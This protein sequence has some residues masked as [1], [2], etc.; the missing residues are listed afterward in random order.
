MINIFYTTLYIFLY[1]F[2][3]IDLNYYVFLGISI[4]VIVKG[5]NGHKFSPF[6]YLKIFDIKYSSKNILEMFA[7]VEFFVYYYLKNGVINNLES[8]VTLPSLIIF[9]YFASFISL[10]EENEND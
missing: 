2:S 9:F 5:L 10:N 6:R 8:I 7:C 3:E 1:Q 4:M